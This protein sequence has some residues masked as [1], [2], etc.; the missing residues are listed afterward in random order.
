MPGAGILFTSIYKGELYFLL[1]REN[2]YCTNGKFTYC[3][4]GGGM[5]N[6][7]SYKQTAARECS[8]EMRGFLGN[9]NDL[10]KLLKTHTYYP[11]YIDN[12]ESPKT[13][14]IFIIPIPYLPYLPIIFNQTS[15]ITSQY[16]QSK[17]L[18]TSKI[19][20][21]D[22]MLWVSINN[23]NIPLRKFFKQSMEKI[24]NRQEEIMNY[25]KKNLQHT[26]HY[27]DKY[28]MNPHKYRKTMKKCLIKYSKSNYSRKYK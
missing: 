7:E 12:G 25:I 1:G 27:F 15:G 10:L 2:K 20:E 17:L 4:F 3:D 18:R 26:R 19:L 9:Y 22:K 24:R 16:M 5:D 13:Y 23:C 21:K 14:R 11:L 6:N 28:T 8:E